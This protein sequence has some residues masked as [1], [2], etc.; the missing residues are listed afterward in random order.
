MAFHWSSRNQTPK[1]TP[2]CVCLSCIILFRPVKTTIRRTHVNFI[3]S[4][5]QFGKKEMRILMVG[6]DAAG[7]TTIL[8]KLKLGE[9]KQRIDRGNAENTQDLIRFILIPLYTCLNLPSPFYSCNNYP[10]HRF[11]CRNCRIQEHLVH[12]VGCRWTG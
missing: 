5:K 9:G 1:S 6:L 10:H 4:P 7:K 8:Y 2:E 11:Q 12:R 3:F